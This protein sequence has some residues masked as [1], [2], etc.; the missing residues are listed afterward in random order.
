M[1]FF[2]YQGIGNDFILVEAEAARQRGLDGPMAEQLCD[3]RYGIGADGVLIVS[4]RDGAGQ[5]RVYNADGSVPEMCGNGL[6]CAALHFFRTGQ[7]AS[8]FDCETG[9]GVHRCLV[10]TGK[11]SSIDT[12]RAEVTVTMRVPSLLPADIPMISE[13]PLIDAALRFDSNS[14]TQGERDAT[15]MRWTLVSMG[16]PHAVTFDPVDEALRAELGARIERDDRFPEGVN[17]GFASLEQGEIGLAVWERGVGL[18]QACGTGAC[19]AAV[20]AAVTGRCSSER[21]IPVRLPGGTL[22]IQVGAQTQGDT[23]SDPVRMTGPAQWV[24]EGNI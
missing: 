14:S 20:A 15:E 8:E 23:R 12:R 11:P 18:T 24:F 4:A 1:Q 2:K 5:M 6:R 10:S 17:V 7:T 22:K 19:A 16:N 21:P 13:Q 9:A 3:R